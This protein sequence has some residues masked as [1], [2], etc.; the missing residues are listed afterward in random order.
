MFYLMFLSLITIIFV[1]RFSNHRSKIREILIFFHKS[2][3]DGKQQW[4][5]HSTFN[6]LVFMLERLA[7]VS[8][9]NYYPFSDLL[10]TLCFNNTLLGC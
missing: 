5:N 8:Q 1:I 10:L 9:T 7:V 3:L 4:I 6:I 2:I